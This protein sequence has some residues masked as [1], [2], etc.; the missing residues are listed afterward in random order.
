MLHVHTLYPWI[1]ATPKSFAMNFQISG[2]RLR[3]LFFQYKAVDYI[4]IEIMRKG[5]D[6]KLFYFLQYM[7]YNS[8]QSFLL[9]PGL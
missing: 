1:V 3:V 5:H 2:W 7:F 4:F 9:A 6:L 8:F